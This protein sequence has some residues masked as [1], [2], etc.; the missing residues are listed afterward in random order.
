[1]RNLDDGT[2]KIDEDTERD[3][4]IALWVFRTIVVVTALGLGAFIIRTLA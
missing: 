2:V 4:T 3:H 1:M